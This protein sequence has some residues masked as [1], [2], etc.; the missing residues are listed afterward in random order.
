MISPDGRYLFFLSFRS[1][2]CH[3]YWVSAKVI[4]ELRSVSSE[5]ND[6]SIEADRPLS[7]LKG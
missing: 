3:P 2:K 4:E 5:S 6:K 1:G 7:Y